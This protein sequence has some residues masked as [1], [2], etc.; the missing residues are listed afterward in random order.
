MGHL[1]SMTDLGYLY[2]NGLE[3]DGRVII[4]PN[5]DKALQY[6]SKGVEK[7]FPRALNNLAS[8]YY[9]DPKYKNENKRMDYFQRAAEAEYVKSLY[10]LGIIYLQGEMGVQDEEKAKSLIKRSAEKGDLQGKQ[11]YIEMM[12]S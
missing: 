7:N 1:Q 10:N 6:Y 11:Q 9:N 5:S 4:E 2:E 12:L 8:F 3:Q